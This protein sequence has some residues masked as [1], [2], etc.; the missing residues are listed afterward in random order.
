MLWK[1]N[2]LSLQAIEKNGLF[3]NA[4]S[5]KMQKNPLRVAYRNFGNVPEKRSKYYPFGLVMAG[6]SSKAAGSVENKYKYNGKEEQLKEFGDESVLEW[7][8]Y[9]AR[10]QDPQ[11]GRWFAIDP[12]AEKMLG[13]S[14]YN[15]TFNNPIRFID[16]DGRE[17]TETEGGTRYTGLDAAR[18]FAMIRGAMNNEKLWRSAISFWNSGKGIQGSFNE[19][20]N[21]NYRGSNST[22]FQND[23]SSLSKN[24]V[25][26]LLLAAI[27]IGNAQINVTNE[28]SGLELVTGNIDPGG[29]TSISLLNGTSN[30][31][32]ADVYYNPNFKGPAD[33][34]NFNSIIILG[35]ELFH[36]V[37]L[38]AV[39]TG[40][41]NP[42]MPHNT[43]HESN[44]AY[45][46]EWSK[47]HFG[48]PNRLYYEA[49]AVTYDNFSRTTQKMPA[50]L[51]YDFDDKE[52]FKKW[53][54]EWQD[55]MYKYLT[56]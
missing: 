10:M 52:K 2:L 50:R 4:I 20:R 24:I 17:V 45:Y 42:I 38:I 47:K 7:P 23:I 22:Q 9:G 12:T 29:H 8:D 51:N 44:N 55:I 36:A 53:F 54:F 26:A 56:Q 41:V 11:L 15:Y 14:P 27:D 33:G 19:A 46:Q 37:D 49:R 40:T 28:P 3:K 18:A 13:W 16:P 31:Y 30:V 6:I 48:H 34:V 21:L 32:Y 43:N 35:H 39:A 25:G 5:E 1:H